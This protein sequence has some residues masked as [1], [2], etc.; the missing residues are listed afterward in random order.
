ME[1]LLKG[2]QEDNSEDRAE[3]ARKLGMKGNREAV[4]HLIHALKDEEPLVRANAALAL[5]HLP[6]SKKTVKA[7]ITLLEDEEWVVRHDA[8]IALGELGVDEG[9][10]PLIKLLDD[11]VL[12]VRKKT[13]NALGKIGSDEGI[14]ELETHVDDLEVLDEMVEAFSLNSHNKSLIK[15][16]EMGTDDIRIKAIAG[17]DAAP[18]YV[19]VLVKALKDDSWRVREEA[20]RSLRGF[21]TKKVLKALSSRLKDDNPH[22]IIEALRSLVE[23]GDSEVISLLEGIKDHPEPS[24]REEW[25]RG[26]SALGGNYMDLIEAFEEED[27]PRVRWTL[28]ESMGRNPGCLDELRETYSKAL[29]DEK[30]LLACSLAWAGDKTGMDEVFQA[31]EDNRWK[32]RQKSLE[33]VRNVAFDTL[34]K[35]EKK[36]LIRRVSDLLEDPDKWVR[37]ESIKVLRGISKEVEEDVSLSE[38]LEKR[39]EIE[40]DEDVKQALKESLDGKKS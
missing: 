13:I 22:V 18:K 3:C 34:N 24:I 6:E 4:P 37:I 25:G 40:V 17:I 21:S 39:M 7:L 23:A 28:A 27:N 26:V 30:I 32:V 11:P 2:L 36:G 15:L 33:A 35:K 20:A 14:K 29:G 8:A 16:Y 10:K 12:D 38:M 9:T 5:G 1:K 31:L 19:D